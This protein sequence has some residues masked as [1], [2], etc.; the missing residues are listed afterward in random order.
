MGHQPRETRGPIETPEPDRF[1]FAPEPD[2]TSRA[3]RAA[4]LKLGELAHLRANRQHVTSRAKRA[5]LLKQSRHM[6]RR[7]SLT[8]VTSRANAR[9]Y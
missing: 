7:K 1:R 9:P 3:K 8:G 5:A 4:L 6:R 2:V